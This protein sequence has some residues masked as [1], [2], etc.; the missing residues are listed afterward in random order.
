MLPRVRKLE[1]KFGD[2]LVAVG[3]HAGKYVEERRTDS[4]ARAC[5][6]LGVHHPVLND[7]QF[8]TWRSYVVQAW[9]TLAFLDPDGY[10][11][12]REAGELP[13]EALVAFVESLLASPAGSRVRRE[14]FELAAPPPAPEPTPLLFPGKLLA[15]D[16]RLFVSDTGHH[17]VL[18]LELEAGPRARLIRRFGSGE[19]GFADGS[20][21]SAAFREPQ[22]LALH[23]GTL[24]VADRENHAV[25]EVELASGHVATLAGTGE[26]GG[27][28]RPGAARET[29]LRSPWD[30]CVVDG[31]LFVAMA[32]AHQIWC[33]DLAS[34]WLRPHAGSGAEAIDDGPLERAT[35]AQPSGLTLGADRLYFADAESSAV[36]WADPR[37]D[38]RVGTLVGTGLFDFGDRDGTGDDVR[39]QHPLAVAWHA[40]RVLVADS[41][42]GKLKSVDPASCAC[43]T[44]ELEVAGSAPDERPFSEPGG[45]SVEGDLLYVAD[46]G[47]HRIVRVPLAGGPA[48]V[49]EIDEA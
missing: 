20:G 41:Y 11:V 27:R 45:L 47:N 29:A 42:N 5:Q 38:G 15:T 2:A 49:L 26:L 6:R 34:G 24:L 25:R 10:L 7:R 31:S 3:V 16:S 40:G 18:E 43:A 19:P 35:L 14:P 12:A 32:G 36:R 4:I 13:F 23:E 44:V 33:L 17:R 39:L 28:L 30:L 8:R 21:E 37:E 9:P 46:T 48:Q 22:G 1:E